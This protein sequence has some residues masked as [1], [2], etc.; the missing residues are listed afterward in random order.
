MRIPLMLLAA[1]AC[2]AARAGDFQPN[3]TVVRDDITYDVKADGTFTM[4][5]FEIVRINTDQGVKEHA[6]LPLVYSASLQDMEVLEAYTTTRDGKR[7]DVA[8]DKILVQQSPQSADAP[9][10]D[11]GKVKTVVFPGVEIGA[12]LT[13]H[14]RKTQKTPLFPGQFSMIE[15]AESKHA[16][17]SATITVKAPASFKLQIDAVD[18]PGGQLPSETP[19][20]QLWR[21]SLRK[22][23]A[24]AP[25]LGSVG[26]LDHSP[27]VAVSSFADYAAVAHAY[28][29][30]ARSKAAVTPAIRKL[31]DEVTRGLTDKRAQA[32]ALYRWVS[33]NIRYV[34]IFLD[35]GGVVPHDAQEIAQV[36]YGDCKDHAT[37]LQALLA[38]KG[39]KS[40]PVLVNVTD[41]YW[42]P[43]AATATG[44]FNHM[45]SY[46][47][48]WDLY[49]DATPG[50][51]MFGALP[52]ME[53]GKPALIIDDGQGRS[54]LVTLPVADPAHDRVTVKTTMTVAKDGS[55]QGSTDVG[56][57][58]TFDILAR[59]LFGSLPPGVEPQVASRVLTLTGQT[60]TGTYKHGDSRELA[61]PFAY[62]T[63]FKLPGYAQLPG[64]G[65]MM[66]PPG[67]SSFSNIAASF[68][69]LG[70]EKRELPM[71]FAGRQVTEA[72]TLT[73]PEGVK[74]SALPKPAR[75]S[76]NFGTYESSYRLEGQTITVQRKLEI[77]VPGQLV[78]PA[79][80][81]ALRDMAFA[82]MRDLRTQVVY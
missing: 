62:S 71:P 22:V 53:Q 79:D 33:A 13:I 68:D 65:A 15:A 42:L 1:I 8:P 31:A 46:L 35:F 9:M 5:E 30:R 50:L 36:R 16:Y 45:I 17:E 6:Q 70:L 74:V 69:L 28:E 61:K 27:R 11:D 57:T 10:F 14:L 43:K 38:A 44:V 3:L 58:G 81:P 66:V 32:E 20:A 23:P 64:P 75:V 25:E 63:E 48:Q 55:V 4:D 82:V 49:V 41:A 21:W 12:T 67:L 34:A 37:I 26:D 78:Q 19:E 47:P 76:S 54:K 51:A 52:V 80:Y 39:I 59:Q 77:R 40:S 73:L 29:E 18:M 72:I 24:R 56:N 60:G 7:M 2:A